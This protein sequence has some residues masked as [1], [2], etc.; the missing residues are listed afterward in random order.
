M[1]DVRIYL[2]KS[3]F[4]ANDVKD[5]FKKDVINSYTLKYFLFLD[6]KFKDRETPRTSPVGA[7]LS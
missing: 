2:G 3:D 7:G 5:Y 6:D 1:K 4:N